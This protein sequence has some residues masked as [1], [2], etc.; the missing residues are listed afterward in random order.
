MRRPAKMLLEALQMFQVGI[1]AQLPSDPLSL[2][3]FPSPTTKEGQVALLRPLHFLPGRIHIVPGPQDLT[4][5]NRQELLGPIFQDLYNILYRAKLVAQFFHKT[6]LLG[7][8]LGKSLSR[9]FVVSQI[10]VHLSKT[11]T[12]LPFKDRLLI[13]LLISLTF[14]QGDTL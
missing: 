1:A 5:M 14:R 3:G 4:L 13:Y 8:L 11:L 10:R 7:K 2:K 6:D 9:T 12:F